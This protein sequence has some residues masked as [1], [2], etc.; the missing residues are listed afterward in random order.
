MARKNL[1]KTKHKMKNI[2]IA[3]MLMAAAINLSAADAKDMPREKAEKLG[4]LPPSKPAQP[5]RTATDTA[6]SIANDLFHDKELG[7]ETA[8][9][10][11]TEDFD[12]YKES[13]TIGGN[14]FVTK[15]AGFHAGIGLKDLDDQGIDLVEFGFVG[16]IPVEK[17]RLALLY[18]VGAECRFVNDTESSTKPSTDRKKKHV[19]PGDEDTWAVYAEA[20][21]LLRANQ[22]FDLF[23]KVRGVR[24]VEG[25]EGEHIGIF[26]GANIPLKLF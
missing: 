24:P 22:Y 25:A 8:Y 17:L 1:T 9:T 12:K 5:Q 26:V 20:G 14:Y 16:R 23:A 7:I 2:I 15:G 11:R 19:S 13:V 10:V 6:K 21:V 3:V 18:G 4:L